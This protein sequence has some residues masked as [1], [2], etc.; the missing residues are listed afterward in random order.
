MAN[1]TTPAARL[2]A[3]RT[4]RDELIDTRRDWDEQEAAFLA[5]ELAK[6]EAEIAE[7]EAPQPA[8]LRGCAR[9]AVAILRNQ[10]AEDGKDGVSCFSTE[11][12]PSMVRAARRLVK[13]GV[14]A[15]VPAPRGEFA[16]CA[17]PAWA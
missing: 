3:L 4:E 16:V 5:P 10:I 9:V 8:P 2:A 6:I 15:K 11:H 7:L 13:R 1:R 14:F 17:G 12:A